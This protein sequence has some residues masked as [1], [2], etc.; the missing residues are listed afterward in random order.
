M[1]II[2]KIDETGKFSVDKSDNLSVF[3]AIGMLELTKKMMLEPDEVEEVEEVEEIVEETADED[4][5]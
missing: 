5:Q 1:E 2:I 3:V 4:M